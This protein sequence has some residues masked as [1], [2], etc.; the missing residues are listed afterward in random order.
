MADQFSSIRREVVSVARKCRN[1]VPG[2][3]GLKIDS[4]GVYACKETLEYRKIRVSTFK[5]VSEVRKLELG[6]TGI[7]CLV[8]D[9]GPESSFIMDNILYFNELKI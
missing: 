9:D 5:L 8:D 3:I 1:V 2:L 7:W 6:I 4:S